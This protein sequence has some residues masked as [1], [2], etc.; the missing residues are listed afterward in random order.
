[1]VF[2][3]VFLTKTLYIF[4]F[5]PM[6]ATCTA[7]GILLY[8]ITQ[9]IFGE[10]YQ[11]C[12]SSL[13]NFLQSPIPCFLSNPNIFLIT[14]FSNTLSLRAFLSMTDQGSHS[15]KKTEKNCGCVYINL[16]VFRLQMIRQKFIKSVVTSIP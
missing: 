14:L 1:V 5:N 6:C 12:C 2:A 11:S 13:C 9:I 15:S 16:H 3:S 7:H 8:L 10:E 4:L